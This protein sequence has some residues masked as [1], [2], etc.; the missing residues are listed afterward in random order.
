MQG[1]IFQSRLIYYIRSLILSLYFSFSLFAKQR[2]RKVRK[3]KEYTH[4]FLCPS[5]I[6]QVVLRTIYQARYCGFTTRS[7]LT[8]HPSNCAPPS[9][10]P[11][12]T[13]FAKESYPPRLPLTLPG[14]D[15][16]QAFF[17]RKMQQCVVF[18]SCPTFFL[19]VSGVN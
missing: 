8:L 2:K 14:E 19:F 11:K 10:I 13:K 1:G 5:S 3:E 6:I 4:C 17:E 15:Y 12:L 18:L 9:R 7:L 16:N